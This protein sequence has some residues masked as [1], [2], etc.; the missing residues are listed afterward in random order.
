MDIYLLKREACWKTQVWKI[1]YLFV[2]GLM[3][4]ILEAESLRCLFAIQVEMSSRQLE[5]WAEVGTCQCTCDRQ[6]V[7]VHVDIEDVRGQSLVD[8]QCLEVGGD[9][10][11]P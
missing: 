4:S 3:H 8:R 9:W 11:E 1:R 10:E 7:N 5:C 2:W 6:G